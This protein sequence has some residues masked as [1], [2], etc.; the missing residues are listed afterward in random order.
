[1]NFGELNFGELN[2][3]ELKLGELRRTRCHDSDHNVAST[4][5]DGMKSCQYCWLL[6]EKGEVFAGAGPG[7]KADAGF[8]GSC[9]KGAFQGQTI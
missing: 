2:F 5:C 1:L 4:P 6:G 8:S 9:R 7:P 3:G